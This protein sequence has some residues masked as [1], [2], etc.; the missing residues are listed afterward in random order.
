MALARIHNTRTRRLGIAPAHTRVIARPS[1]AVSRRGITTSRWAR[2]V[3]HREAVPVLATIAI[4]L[5]IACAVIVN[6][7]MSGGGSVLT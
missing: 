7:A 2:L 1:G 5:L 3:P 4:T 6:A